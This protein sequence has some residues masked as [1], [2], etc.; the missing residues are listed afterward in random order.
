M[1]TWKFLLPA[2]LVLSTSIAC[3]GNDTPK[4]PELMDTKWKLAS[5]VTNR[6]AKIPEPNLYNQYWLIFKGDSTLEG[7]TSSSVFRGAY[8]VNTQTSSLLITIPEGSEVLE[9]LEGQFFVKSLKAVRSFELQKS[10]LKLYYSET[11]Y[12]LFKPN[13]KIIQVLNNEPVI[14]RKHN[15]TQEEMYHQGVADSFAF[16]LQPHKYV[17]ISE[18]VIPSSRIPDEYRVEGR[19]ASIS[20]NI[21]ERLVVHSRPNARFRPQNIIELKSIK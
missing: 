17:S 20:G 18:T 13:C 21:V 10:T 16:E 2:V 1:K 14:I 6:S 5:F 19:S 12:L 4:Q 15:L 9:K 7:R 11:D 3:S 8:K